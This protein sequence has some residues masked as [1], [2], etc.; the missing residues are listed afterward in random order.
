MHQLHK[1]HLRFLHLVN[2]FLSQTHTHALEA[3]CG[4]VSVQ[5][6]PVVTHVV[7]LGGADGRFESV[8]VGL[9]VL[10]VHWVLAAAHF[11]DQLSR[12]QS[13]AIT[14]AQSQLFF[15]ALKEEKLPG[16]PE[17][18]MLLTLALRPMTS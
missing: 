9:D 18:T 7:V 8:Q 12:N 3:K 13:H 10:D 1:V 16:G 11:Q 17:S 15:P 14:A 2:G 5:P 4:P 6:W